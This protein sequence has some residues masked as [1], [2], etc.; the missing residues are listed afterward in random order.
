[1]ELLITAAIARKLTNEAQ[2]SRCEY[3]MFTHSHNKKECRKTS[4]G[5]CVLS[6]FWG[7]FYHTHW[8]FSNAIMVVYIVIWEGQSENWKEKVNW[9]K[10]KLLKMFVFFFQS[11]K[12]VFQVLLYVLKRKGNFRKVIFCLS[13][14]CML[15][16]ISDF[17]V[18]LV[19]V[20][21][22]PQCCWWF[23]TAMTWH[24]WFVYSETLI[25]KENSEFLLGFSDFLKKIPLSST[26]NCTT[27][28][29]WVLLRLE[30]RGVSVKVT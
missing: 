24:K 10:P 6:L 12:K 19:T 3:M 4:Q 7:K 1:M 8:L 16:F 9:K 22:Q 26:S 30:P 25:S 17:H 15:C 11:T 5:D 27:E 28:L 29:H 20:C 23:P 18:H 21:S 14:I 2:N 13:L